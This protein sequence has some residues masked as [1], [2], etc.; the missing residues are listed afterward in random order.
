MLNE[1]HLSKIREEVQDT[2]S[3]EQDA[4]SIADWFDESAHETRRAFQKTIN[5]S[6]FYSTTSVTTPAATTAKTTSATSGTSSYYY[7]YKE[8]KD[9][10][11]V[12][13]YNNDFINLIHNLTEYGI[14]VYTTT[15]YPANTYITSA[16]LGAFFKH[17]II[18]NMTLENFAERYSD[19]VALVDKYYASLKLQDAAFVTP[20]NV[21]TFLIRDNL[22]ICLPIILPKDIHYKSRKQQTVLPDKTDLWVQPKNA[23]V[24]EFCK[25]YDIDATKLIHYKDEKW[26][27]A[28]G[29]EVAEPE[30]VDSTTSTITANNTHHSLSAFSDDYYYDTEARRKKAAAH[31]RR[32]FGDDFIEII[33]DLNTMPATSRSS[34]TYKKEVPRGFSDLLPP[35]NTY[36]LNKGKGRNKLYGLLDECFLYFPEAITNHVSSFLNDSVFSDQYYDSTFK[37]YNKYSNIVVAQNHRFPAYLP[38]A[39]I[40][41][42]CFFLPPLI[43]LQGKKSSE[44]LINWITALYCNSKNMKARTI[45]QRKYKIQ[46]KGNT[47]KQIDIALRYCGILPYGKKQLEADKSTQVYI[48]LEN[49]ERFLFHKGE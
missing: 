13:Q 27:D 15:R 11:K 29:K 48:Y 35:Y 21:L 44:L 40:F 7:A 47:R 5:N 49:L 4:K 46:K 16:N 45:K 28:A 41:G 14:E 2:T 1:Q 17:P 30:L 8:T 42:A 3:K 6:S 18:L 23:S 38:A 36:V 34:N 31:V 37:L 12:T 25:H 10:I 39:L 20:N 9:G 32:E 33:D 19:I 22:P 43:T 26:Y 24:E